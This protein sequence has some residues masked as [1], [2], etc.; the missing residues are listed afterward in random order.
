MAL[1]GIIFYKIKE[2]LKFLE[3]GKINK[4]QEASDSEFIF[5]IRR[6]KENYKLLISLCANY[7]RVHLT[8]ENYTFPPEPKSF[9]MLLRKYFEG[10]QITSIDTHETDRILIISC[11]KYNEM[12]DYE[13][14]KIVIEIMGRYSNLI[15]LEN[16]II[17][18]AYRHIGVLEIRTILPNASYEY[19]DLQGKINPLN[20]SLEQ[21]YQMFDS[22][23]TPKDIV[24]K[25]IGVSMQVACK[26]FLSS[27]PILCL[28]EYIHSNYPCIYKDGSK[29]DYTYFKYNEDALAYDSFSLLLDNYYK[30]TS[31]A[32][33]IKHKTNNIAS[34]IDKQLNKNESKKTKLLLELSDAE[35][36][37][38]YRLYG[39][40]LIANSH[41]KTKSE[42]IDV[43]NY[44]TNETI[45]IKLDAR[46]DI[47]GNSKL[48]FKK[49]QKA[50]NAITHINE[51]LSKIDEEINYFTLLKEQVKI[52]DLKDV[53]EI[54]EELILNK[55]IP[56][57]S[58]QDKIQKTKVTTYILPS[59]SMVL[60]GKNNI[61]N[62]LITHKLS[63]PNELWF[64]VKDA[65]GS[66][67]LLK[68]CD[69][70]TEEEIRL[71]ANLASYYSSLQQSSSVAVN[72]TKIRNIKKI[73]GRKNCF[74]SIKNEKTIFI[75]PDINLINN[76]EIKK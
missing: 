34:F 30:E 58:K 3:T 13:S 50:K 71:C 14:K 9:T 10:A 4:I 24:Q 11:S 17:K 57:K 47:I 36:L 31:L 61:Q 65:P 45:T 43:L 60:L 12:G 27:N 66:H 32:E 18:E 16:N 25:L 35:K 37:D 33:R 1:D 49:Y 53:L 55:Y 28:Y 59:G 21:L 54:Q 75:D 69:D 70:Y 64:H 26:C 20:L 44:Y 46:Y 63:Q 72:Y 52:G 23:S 8:Y 2:E 38:K 29:T 76:L 41:I 62:E 48:Y 6:N 67:V 5:T 22:N 56:T 19:P 15:I 73:P 74:V 7:P 40:L 68:K 51:Q 42:K 39:E